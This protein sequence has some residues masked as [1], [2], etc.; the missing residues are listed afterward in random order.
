MTGMTLRTARAAIALAATMG[1]MLSGCATSM[2]GAVPTARPTASSSPS[3]TTVTPPSSAT[4]MPS[5]TPSITPTAS[6]TPTIS[7]ARKKL[8]G[9]CLTKTLGWWT[10]GNCVK[11]AQQQLKK[12][13][14]LDGPVTSSLGVAAINGVLN[15]QRSR[16]LPGTGTVTK[17]TW[18]ALALQTP[19]IP[20]VIPQKCYAKGV[21]I[22]VDQAHRKAFWFRDGKLVKTFKIRV[23]GFTV[24]A[25]TKQWRLF[26]TA[27]GTWKVYNKNI[28]PPSET[29][30]YGVMPYSTMFYPDMYF[31]YSADF[32]ARGYT[33]SSHGCVNIG[34]LADAIWIF[35]H[36][37][38]GA[39]VYTYGNI[40]PSYWK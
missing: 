9:A 28:D 15:Y 31:H 7:P 2:P 8:F 40:L 24:G 1:L 21:V 6:P 27:N 10:S 34:V 11:L 35:K 33:R 4:P 23:G 13:G 39:K 12:V 29:Y 26:P 30:G 18:R 37:P 16:G 14:Y 22:C 5:M 3:V 17:A 36:T 38:I 19:V 32:R 25:K 20:L